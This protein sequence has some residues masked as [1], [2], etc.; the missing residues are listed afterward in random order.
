MPVALLY[1]EGS[2]GSADIRVLKKILR[3]PT[4]IP[5]GGK[6]GMGDRILARREVH[7]QT[8]FGLLDGDFIEHLAEPRNVPSRWETKGDATTV[9][10][11]WRWERKE[12]E[13]YL[14][15]PAIVERTIKAE[16]LT[17]VHYCEM[18]ERAAGRVAIYEAARTAL[19]LS[20]A[21][22]QTITV[23]IRT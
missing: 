15:D 11:G 7:G 2:A 17:P 4:L 6:H 8:V 23:S 20:S 22:V 5:A 18:L 10:L 16:R 3:G 9:H 14:I 21:T 19:A 12:I 13:N 1:C